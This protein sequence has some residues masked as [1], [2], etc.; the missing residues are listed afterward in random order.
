MIG[1]LG[2]GSG[3]KVKPQGQHL[4]GMFNFG[5]NADRLTACTGLMV[6]DLQQ[7]FK[8][9]D[10]ILIVVALVAVGPCL[11]AAQGL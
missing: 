9:Q 2:K 11:S 6:D 10:L 1:Q 8:G 4:G 5:A 3:Q 7:F